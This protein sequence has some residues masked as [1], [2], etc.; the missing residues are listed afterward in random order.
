MNADENSAWARNGLVDPQL[1][2]EKEP[3]AEQWA[4]YKVG[5]NRCKQLAAGGCPNLAA[6]RN[7]GFCG[8][9][10]Q[11]WWPQPGERGCLLLGPEFSAR[12]PCHCGLAKCGQI[13]C[14][15]AKDRLELPSAKRNKELRAEHVRALPKEGRAPDLDSGRKFLAHWH[16]RPEHKQR[17]PVTGMWTLLD[18]GPEGYTDAINGTKWSCAV[19][20]FP[21]KEYIASVRSARVLPTERWLHG[22]QSTPRP[23]VAS[24]R[25]LA[26]RSTPRPDVAA[27]APRRQATPAARRR[28]AAPASPVDSDPQRARALHQAALQEQAH[29]HAAALAKAADELQ[30][31]ARVVHGQKTTM[32]VE[33]LAMR[34]EL[35][36]VRDLG[37]GSV[38]AML[39]AAS[40]AQASAAALAAALAAAERRAQDAEAALQEQARK[41][42][43][44]LAKAADERTQEARVMRAR[45]GP[46]RWETLRDPDVG[47]G[48]HVGAYTWFRSV[49]ANEL[50]LGALNKKRSAED[51][52]ILSR[53]RPYQKTTAALRRGKTPPKSSTAAGVRGKR[54]ILN[55]QDQY[56]VFCL[57]TKAG[58]T[59]KLLA[60]N[61]AN[62]PLSPPHLSQCLA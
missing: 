3:T 52:G 31:R 2:P 38:A 36:Q 7:F 60:I 23:L 28:V 61:C 18:L 30:G 53:L 20:N 1:Q 17:D 27:P 56:L 59:Q 16:Y 46:V 4:Y 45:W 40:A 33:L 41:H 34:Q 19:P 25:P 44:A 14:V 39:D 9:C 43:A 8:R 10:R 11:K 35:K 49:A 42:A 26:P 12:Y 24:R 62:P 29:K 54:P 47:W 57:H 50:F 6:E 5:E 15:T 21:L 48:Q 13:G 32:E 22:P 51:A 55:F 58:W 37:F